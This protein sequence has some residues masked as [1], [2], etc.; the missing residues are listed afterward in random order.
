MT[1]YEIWY[2]PGGFYDYDAL[3]RGSVRLPEILLLT[4]NGPPDDNKMTEVSCRFGM[5][6]SFLQ[7]RPKP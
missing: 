1:R 6:R 5:Q 4:L 3:G 2:A 7:V